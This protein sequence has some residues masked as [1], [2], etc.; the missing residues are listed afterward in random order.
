MCRHLPFL[1]LA[2]ILGGCATSPSPQCWTFVC[3]SDLTPELCA[4]VVAGA[5]RTALPFA[6]PQPRFAGA[7]VTPTV[8]GFEI[9]IEA[10]PDGSLRMSGSQRLAI[11]TGTSPACP[12]PSVEV[13]AR[14]ARSDAGTSKVAATLIVRAAAIG[15]EV[16]CD[17]GDRLRTRLQPAI[18]RALSWAGAPTTAPGSID[19]PALA[20]LVAHRLL[21]AAGKAA[22][23][24]DLDAARPWLHNAV[25]LGA[26]T[27]EL[28]L[29][30]AELAHRRGDADRARQ[31]RWQAMLAADDPA[32]RARIAALVGEGGSLGHDR[33]D[34]ML[35]AARRAL[36]SGDP[37][38]AAD[39]LHSAR[40]VGPDPARDYRLQQ[41]LS[42]LRG[43]TLSALA[44][45]LLAREHA[46]WR[47]LGIDLAEDLR[48]AGLPRLADLAERRAANSVARP[49]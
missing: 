24:G 34:D 30:M 22:A 25:A 37:A 3:T 14:S 32:Q 48:N 35:W 23:R 8:Q 1:L 28:H 45:S 43:E 39:L 6:D 2:G 26:D 29:W 12:W 47:P 33:A 44:S 17:L 31:Q 13:T 49:Q 9:C 27:P 42:R 46:P 5:V 20:R 18:E 40:R 16:H 4:A 10:E 19:D 36:A 38:A 11:A 7:L 15:S 21:V 41:A